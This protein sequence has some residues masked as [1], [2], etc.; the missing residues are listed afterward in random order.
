MVRTINKKACKVIIRIWKITHGPPNTHCTH[1]G[2]NAIRMKTTSPAYI[3]PN[4]LKAR[5]R[6]FANNSISCNNKLNGASLMPNGAL[7]NS[8]SHPRTPFALIP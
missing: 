1:H 8:T 5:E 2:N 3:L 7:T 6:G 4:N